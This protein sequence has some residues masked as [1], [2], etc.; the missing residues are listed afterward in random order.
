MRAY[1]GAHTVCISQISTDPARAELCVRTTAGFRWWSMLLTTLLTE[2][3]RA[4]H[5][6][7]F[8]VF[9]EPLTDLGR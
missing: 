5:H 6:S 9:P 8:D 7:C 2:D 1:D 3:Q 4:T